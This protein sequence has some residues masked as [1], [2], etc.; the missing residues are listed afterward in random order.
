[1]ICD[2][3]PASV[4][5]CTGSGQPAMSIESREIPKTWQLSR[6][7]ATRLLVDNTASVR[8]GSAVREDRGLLDALAAILAAGDLEPAF[9]AL[10]LTLPGE[11]DIARE[12]GR[13]VDPDVAER[14]R[15]TERN[16]F[17]GALGRQDPGNP[18]DLEWI[19]FLDLPLTHEP[20]GSR[21]DRDVP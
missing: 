10:A 13:D 19:A 20:P 7:L 8:A 5:A 16:D 11:A 18:G 12:I 9:I 15:M 2:R 14:Q 17:R 4:V 21:V 3:S 1:M 6:A